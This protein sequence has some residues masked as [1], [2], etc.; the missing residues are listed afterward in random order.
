MDATVQARL[1]GEAA[2]ALARLRRRHG[3]TASQAVREALLRLA[4]EEGGA[5]G[6]PR[7]VGLGCFD[8]GLP[9]LATNPEHLKDFGKR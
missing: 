9:D 8:S 2:R 3:W 6:G 4:A 7:V 5:G 1:D